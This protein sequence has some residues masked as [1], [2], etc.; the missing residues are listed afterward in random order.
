MKKTLT[1]LI[2]LVFACNQVKSQTYSQ[3]FENVTT[4]QLLDSGWVISG[5]NIGNSNKLSGTK[6]LVTQSLNVYTSGS[7]F[8]TTA[9]F[10]GKGTNSVQF[11]HVINNASGN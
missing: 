11:Q 8:I 2:V 4:T 9:Y 7:T 1:I 3:T 6:E 5:V 10:E